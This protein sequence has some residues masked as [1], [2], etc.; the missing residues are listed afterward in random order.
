MPLLISYTEPVLCHYEFDLSQAWFVAFDITNANTGEVKRKQFRGGINYYHTKEERLLEG[1]A[2]LEH[3]RDKLHKGQYNPWATG[4]EVNPIEI[5]ETIKDALAKIL[6]LKKASL[7]PK[8]FR[9]YRNIHDMFLKWL[10]LYHYQKLRLHQFTPAMAQA[11]LDYLL[12]E[13]GYAGKTHNNQHGILHTFFGAMMIPGRKWIAANPF[14]GVAMLPEDQG[15]NIPYT[16]KERADIAKYLRENDRRMYYAIHFLFHCYIRKT[17]LT[18]VRV[19]DIDWTNKTIKINAQASKNR[20][21]DSVAIP[22]AFLPTLLEMGLDMAPKHFYIFGKK[23]ETCEHRMT[24][25]DDISDRYLDLKIA[26]GYEAGDG[27]T[28]Y[29][30]KHSGAIAYWNLLKDPYALM[31]QLRHS[32]LQTTMIYLRSLGLNPNFHFLNANVV[33]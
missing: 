8:S 6:A 29:A 26:M 33:L 24:R 2:L 5:P 10:T 27:K 23:M 22:E 15:D 1:N 3:W 11:Y 19:G 9:G 14:A 18:T 16:E 28:F 17:E 25:P 7:K 30:W 12:I 31:R 21:Q 32:D 13:K 20:I 4:Q